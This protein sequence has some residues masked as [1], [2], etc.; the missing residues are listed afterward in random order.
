M[1]DVDRERF[2][3]EVIA[4][5]HNTLTRSSGD[6]GTRSRAT[7]AI[8]SPPPLSQDRSSHTGGTW[9]PYAP[10]VGSLPPPATKRPPL[11]GPS[12][13]GFHF[14]DVVRLENV[15]FISFRW[16]ET[17]AETFIY[18]YDLRTFVRRNIPTDFAASIASMN[19]LEQLGTG[20]HLRTPLKCIMGLTF[21][22]A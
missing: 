2:Y 18:M 19:L 13:D 14:V 11:I 4:A 22:D 20:W 9:V 7:S 3:D 12:W 6:T 1:L 8:E 17:E 21:I 16:R 15:A 10:R 5:L